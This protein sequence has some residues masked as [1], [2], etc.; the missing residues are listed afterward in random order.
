MITPAQLIRKISK[1][2]M[3]A[4]GFT[5]VEVIIASSIFTIVSLIGVTVFI[6][7]TRI[8]R[9]IAL[10]NAI[11]EDG[12]FMMERISREIRANT[13]DYEEYY[14]KLVE[15][16]K[17]GEE[18]TCYA[19]RFYNPG[20]GDIENLGA[21]CSDQPAPLG[22]GD[23]KDYPGC[24]IDKTTLDV[25]TGKNPYSGNDFVD[26]NPEDSNAFCDQHFGSGSGCGADSTLHNQS[27]LYLINSKGTKKTLIAPK[28]VNA[29]PNEYALSMLQIEGLDTNT[30]S[31]VDKWVDLSVSPKEFYCSANYDC[32]GATLSDLES[33]LDGTTAGTRY[34]G[35]VPISPLRTTIKDLRFYVS[36]LEDPRKAFAE[37]LTTDVIQQQPH[38]T[39]VMVLQPAESELGTFGGEVPTITLQSTVSSRVYN[40]VKSYTGAET[41]A[42]YTPLPS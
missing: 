4:S 9:K 6:N 33:T 10:E 13:V 8:Q 31:I 14:N 3:K 18:Y 16:K 19:T 25:N 24:I 34:Q 38:V 37:T 40:E 17:Y 23:P 1:R 5:L 35:F 7:V 15:G 27:E 41:C 42:D 12:R 29:S 39:I 32:P 2:G 28:K 30:D 20:E 22:G 21:T 36:P 26:N 11:Y